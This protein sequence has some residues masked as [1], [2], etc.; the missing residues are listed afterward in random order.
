[1]DYRSEVAAI[2]NR[3]GLA[4]PPAG[5]AAIEVGS[6]IDG[7]PLARVPV[8]DATAVAD[9]VGRAAARFADWRDTPAPARGALLRVFGDTVRRHKDAL[10]RLVTIENGKILQEGL[11]EV[12]EVI[13]ICD[14]ARRPVAPA[15]RPDDRQRAARAPAAWRP[16]IRSASSASSSAFNFPVAVWAWNAA[17]ALVCGDTLVWKPSEKTPLAALALHGLLLAAARE[18]GLAERRPAASW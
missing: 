4:L 16:G 7:R 11:G 12:Q 1:M 10:G 18:C 6:P 2:F 14:F 15:L 13:D 17:L 9:A 5:A 8:S 3:L